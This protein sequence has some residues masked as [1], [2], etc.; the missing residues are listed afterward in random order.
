ME[1]RMKRRDALAVLKRKREEYAGD[2]ELGR[3]IERAVFDVRQL[4]KL[5]VKH[6][7]HNKKPR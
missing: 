3:A 4:W 6:G 1:Q 2:A 5:E 7:R